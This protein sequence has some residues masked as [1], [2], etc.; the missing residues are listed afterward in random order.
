[1]MSFAA[2]VTLACSAWGLKQIGCDLLADRRIKRTPTLK[3]RVGDVFWIAAL[4][5]FALTAMHSLAAS[6]N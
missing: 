1:M 6:I 5:C 2:F 3:Q 4:A